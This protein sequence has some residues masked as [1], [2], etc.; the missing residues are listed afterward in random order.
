MC[1]RP[2]TTTSPP[3]SAKDPNNG[4]VSSY[5]QGL[6]LFIVKKLWETIDRWEKGLIGNIFRCKIWR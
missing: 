3:H 5:K 6:S 2:P 1:D 4:N